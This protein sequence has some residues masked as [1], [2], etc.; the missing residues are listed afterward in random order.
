MELGG[1]GGILFIIAS[2][3]GRG[4]PLRYVFYC[5]LYGLFCNNE[6]IQIWGHGREQ[7]IFSE[8]FSGYVYLLEFSAKIVIDWHI[9]F[10]AFFAA[11]WMYL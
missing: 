11:L 4:E 9:G 5:I 7:A 3:L 6:G 1:L 10:F 2:N 8:Y